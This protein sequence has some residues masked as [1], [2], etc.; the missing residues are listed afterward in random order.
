MKKGVVRFSAVGDISL[1]D[2]P[3]CVGFGAHSKFKDLQ[4][5]FPYQY[6]TDVLHKADILFGNLECTLS[7]KGLKKGNYRSVQ[8]RGKAE[9]VKGLVEAGFKILNVANNHSM[10]HG[11]EAFLET[12]NLLE[13]HGIQ[14][15]GVKDE[16]HPGTKPSILEMNGMKIAFLGYSLRPRQYF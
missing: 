10:Q 6:V 14:C 15:C 4:V 1:G 2:H 13:S 7:E 3:L 11:R 16:N 5:T 12:V 8:M 9:Y